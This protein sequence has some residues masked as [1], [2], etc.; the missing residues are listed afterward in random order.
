MADQPTRA[1]LP[2]YDLHCHVIPAFDDGA[3]DEEQALAMLS[4]SAE[5]GVTGMVVTPHSQ[6]ML[7]NGGV[8]VF[9]ERLAAL[10][11]TAASHGIQLQLMPGLEQRLVP[12]LPELIKEKRCLSLNG[13]RYVLVEFDAMQWANYT[14]EVLFQVQLLGLVPLLA[15]VERIRPLQEQ[16][17]RLEQL[18]E[19]GAL[20]QVTGHQRGGR[21]RPRSP[22]RRRGYAPARAGAYPGF[23]YP[24]A[25]GTAGA[26]LGR[27]PPLV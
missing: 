22:A 20:A 6:D 25:H 1:P 17:E 10:R 18:V 9:E 11:E 24:P 14:Q 23:R 8:S 3:E 21:L 13:S 19:H 16:P 27:R 15:H 4:L 26:F 2:R 7:D 5:R 12:D